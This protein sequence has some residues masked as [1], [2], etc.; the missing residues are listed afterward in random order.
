MNRVCVLGVEIDNVSMV[1]TLAQISRIVDGNEF[2]YAVTPNVDHLMRLRGDCTFREIYKAAQ[3]VVA[4][5]VPLVW[6]SRILGRPLKERV[7]G[8]DLFER[9]CALAAQRGYSV[10]LLGGNPGSAVKAGRR[11]SDKHALKIAGW[12]CPD[13]GFEDDPAQN[14][15]IQNLSLIHI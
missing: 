5:G 12:F 10:Y 3:L 4:D 13:L 2:A 9:T 14:R 1:E 11:L 15:A 7:N 6:A 8:T